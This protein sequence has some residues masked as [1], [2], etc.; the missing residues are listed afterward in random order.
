MSITDSGLSSRESLDLDDIPIE[1]QRLLVD[2]ATVPTEAQDN[3]I[4][5]ALRSLR[6]QLEHARL[7]APSPEGHHES[8]TPPTSSQDSVDRLEAVVQRL[9]M[10][11]TKYPSWFKDTSMTL[12]A[13]YFSRSYPYP[14]I[15]RTKDVSRVIPALD[16]WLKKSSTLPI[17]LTFTDDRSYDP[18][19]EDLIYMLVDRLRNNSRRWQSISL[20]LSGTYFPLLFTFTPCD[21]ASLEHLSIN[22]IAF[23]VSRD[24]F[25][26]GRPSVAHL[27]L[28]SATDLK[29]FAYIGPGDF[30]DDR[31]SVA[32]DHL[33]E[34][35][36]TFARTLHLGMSNSLG[37]HFEQLAQCQN[38]TT[39]SLGFG[40][41]FHADQP[42]TL[43]YLR[44]LLVRPI[45]VEYHACSVMDVLILP[46]LQTLEIDTVTPMMR[47]LT[48]W[49]DRQFS[50]LL[51][52][53]SCSLER[54]YIWNVYFPKEELLRCLAHSRNLK[55][56]CFLPYPRDDISDELDISRLAGAELVVSPVVPRLQELKL[57]YMDRITFERI[58][59]MVVSRVGPSANA[60]GVDAL[61]RL[62]EMVVFKEVESTLAPLFP[63]GP[64]WVDTVLWHIKSS[65]PKERLGVEVRLAVLEN[66]NSFRDSLGENL[67][68]SNV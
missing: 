66:K 42:I 37:R 18:V 22:G 68:V 58:M 12:D 35:S 13:F 5:S 54:L 1:L 24:E 52:R 49:R 65:M 31:I 25:R 30:V 53:S 59:K 43:P 36:L 50:N 7:Q 57:A 21:L 67:D 29:S 38:I 27:N 15:S 17:S 63:Q 44:T 45:S 3:A 34:V 6:E 48:Q 14:L 4:A 60:A 9:G 39:C 23:P 46:Q 10:L 20:Q 28:E 40:L 32:W 2:H 8:R 64:A 61:R 47:W 26:W 33:T 11:P 41:P 16:M 55:S 56:L 62:E 19:T 51:A